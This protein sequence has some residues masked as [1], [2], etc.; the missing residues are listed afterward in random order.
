ME[1]ICST[2]DVPA[3]T[4]KGFTLKGKQILV[5]NTG[6]SFFAI[7]AVCSHMQGYLPAGTLSG[8]TVTCPVHGAQY[9]LAT[10]NVLKDVP[11]MMKMATRRQATGLK[12]YAIEV[13]DGQL[14]VDA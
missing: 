8:K 13:R 3:G 7:D 9:D 2:A 11:W 6:G 5:A 1:K 12:T 10:G 14:F 4:M